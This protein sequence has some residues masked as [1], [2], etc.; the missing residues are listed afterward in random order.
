L[1]T[2]LQLRILT[3]LQGHPKVGA[4]W[5]GFALEQVIATLNT[6]N[7]YFWATHAGAELDL[8]VAVGGK[9]YGS[10][11]KYADAPGRNRSMHT[12][13]HDLSLDHLWVI[14]PGQQEYPLN[15]KIA[16]IPLDAALRLFD[17]IG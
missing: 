9:R 17:I 11:V 2:L 5:E 15:D 8:L 7:I 3:D 13:I 4:S 16:V 12:A 1:H 6:S 10:E 14:Y